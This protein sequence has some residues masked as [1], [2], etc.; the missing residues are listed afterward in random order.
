MPQHDRPRKRATAETGSSELGNDDCGFLLSRPM[1][2]MAGVAG[3][4][5]SRVQAR[6]W[7]YPL[8]TLHPHPSA[9]RIEQRLAEDRSVA[10]ITQDLDL[11][12]AFPQVSGQ[13]RRN[14]SLRE[15]SVDVVTVA[16]RGDPAD[17][18]AVVPDRLVTEYVGVRSVDRKADSPQFA[19]RC[20]LGKGRLAADEVGLIEVDETVQARLESPVNGSEL[21]VPRGEILLEAQR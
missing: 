2:V 6:S 16:A 14:V 19:T 5:W 13:T 10:S 12:C 18:L 11:E 9:R 21:A 4:G 17:Y 15:R 8:L 3:G 1:G 20:L 7:C